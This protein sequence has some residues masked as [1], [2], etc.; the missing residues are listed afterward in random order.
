MGVDYKI[1]LQKKMDAF[2]HAVYRETKSFPRDELY[3]VTNQMR[4][5]SLSIV[6]NYTEGFAR[7]RRPVQLQFFEMAYGSL[8][9]TK[10]L[11]HFSLIEEYLSSEQYQDILKLAEEIGAML[12]TELQALRTAVSTKR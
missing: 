11:L 12:W 4:R 3:G 10:Y 9:E 7:V 8:K 5:A 2:A 1:A 6:L